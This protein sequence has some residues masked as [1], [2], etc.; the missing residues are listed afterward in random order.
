VRIGHC[1]NS[2]FFPV[3][4]FYEVYMPASQRTWIISIALIIFNILFFWIK[5]EGKA[6]TT[7]SDLLP[8]IGVVAAVLGTALAVKSFRAPGR[9]RQAWAWLLTGMLLFCCAEIIYGVLEVILNVDVND[10]FPIQTD[11]FRVAAYLPALAGLIMLVLGYKRARFSWGS[12]GNLLFGLLALGAISVTLVYQLLI[13]IM[14]DGEIGILAK[15]VYLYYF[16][17]GLLV[18]FPA[19]FLIYVSG[20]YKKAWLLRPGRYL[21]AG[22]LCLAA[23]TIIHAYLSWNNMYNPGNFLELFRN[24]GY[25]LVCLGGLYQKE[26]LESV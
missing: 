24:A 22:A 7:V 17:A 5:P 1:P 16:S 3:E 26:L 2:T 11:Y 14:R 20:V 21:A 9:A 4:I 13:P 18:I 15:A 12:K 25:L 6:M 8:V 19:A 10:G 23:F